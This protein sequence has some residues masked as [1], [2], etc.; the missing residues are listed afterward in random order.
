[1]DVT[2]KQIAR[3][4]GYSAYI[5]YSGSSAKWHWKDVNGLS[6]EHSDTTFTNEQD[7]YKDCCKKAGLIQVHDDFCA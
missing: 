7:A 1:M 4:A 6:K 3:A 2:H 5:T